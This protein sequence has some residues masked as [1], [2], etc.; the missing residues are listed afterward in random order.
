MSELFNCKEVPKRQAK[1][2]AET[3]V[4]LDVKETLREVQS[5]GVHF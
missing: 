3:S 2:T 5:L 1:T 4:G